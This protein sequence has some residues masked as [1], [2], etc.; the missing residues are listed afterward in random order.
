MKDSF[1]GMIDKWPSPI[2]ARSEVSRFSGGLLHPR[3][4]ANLDARGEGPKT[5]IKQGRKV[6]YPVDALIEFMRE[7]CIIIRGGADD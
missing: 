2:V 5:R 1:A 3:T 6:A 4:L 7:R